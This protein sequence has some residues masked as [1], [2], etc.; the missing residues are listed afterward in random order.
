MARRRSARFVP[1]ND[2]SGEEDQASKRASTLVVEPTENSIRVVSGATL[3]SGITTSKANLLDEGIQTLDMDWE[4]PDEDPQ[5]SPKK[6]RAKP[7]SSRF[8]SLAQAAS[9]ASGAL[10]S[11]VSALGKRSRNAFESGKEKLH[12]L[13]G[14]KPS[15]S[16]LAQELEE[17]LPDPDP[18]PDEIGPVKTGPNKKPRPKLPKGWSYVLPEEPPAK[19]ARLS[20]AD[21]EETEK[22]QVK[23]ETTAK[24]PKPVAK[25]KKR[26]AKDKRWESQGLYAGQDR[27]FNPKLTE[28]QNKLKRQSIG[29]NKENTVLPLP[30]F[31]GEELLT[32]DNKHRDFVLP[33]DVFQPIDPREPKP[34]KGDWQK[35]KSSKSLCPNVP[36]GTVY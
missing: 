14:K 7:K 9:G 27:S 23:P 6:I 12:G 24:T 18:I 21:D 4:M 35:L 13:Q 16:R 17:F 32:T 22:P 15:K 5:D 25:T 1:P 30:M 10:G 20:A 36:D 19:K 8:E 33:F 2:T 31:R 29:S 34:Q 11:T 28:A 3:T 26:R